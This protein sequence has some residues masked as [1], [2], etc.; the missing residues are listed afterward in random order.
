MSR[1]L[2]ALLLLV[3]P[4]G[5]AEPRVPG[6]AVNCNGEAECSGL[7]RGAQERL[8]GCLAEQKRAGYRGLGSV[9]P[10]SCDILRAEANELRNALARIRGR[11]DRETVEEQGG[12]FEVPPLPSS[13]ATAAPPPR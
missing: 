9:P 7:Y 5:C 1:Y 11:K 8:Q 12:G 13:G 10:P 6:E 4:F 3:G 2:F